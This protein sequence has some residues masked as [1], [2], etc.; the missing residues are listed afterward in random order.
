MEEKRKSIETL[1]AKVLET[2]KSLNECKARI[3]TAEALIA[4]KKDEIANAMQKASELIVGS[5]QIDWVES[6]N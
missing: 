5:W 1:A 6:P 3:S 4:S 2:E